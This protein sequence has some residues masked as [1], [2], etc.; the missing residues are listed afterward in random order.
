[1]ADVGIKLS[2]TETA[3]SVAPK[4]CESLRN[5][6]QAGQDMND[7]LQLGDLEEKYK[8]FADRVDKIHDMQKTGQREI[9]KDLQ[10]TRA[11]ETRLKQV[12]QVVRGAGAAVQQAGVTG[13]PGIGSLLGGITSA[14]GPWGMI[15]A[16]LT[17]A[18]VAANALSRQYEKVLPTIMDVTAAFSELRSTTIGTSDSFEKTMKGAMK[19]TQEFG[20]S[21]EQGLTTMRT[22]AAAGVTRAGALEQMGGREGIF[23]WARG[24]GATAEML[25]RYQAMGMRFGVEPSLGFAAG[26]LRQAGMGLGQFQEYLNATLSIFEEGLSRGVVQGFEDI[27]LAQ[28]WISQLGDAFK[29]QYGLNL[30]K[31]MDQAAVKATELQSES[32]VIMF[33]AARR[34][35]K[36]QG[37]D[38]S[39]YIDVMKT[40]E[41]GAQY[42]PA[43]FGQ[44]R[45]IL[46]D[47][48]GGNVNDMAELFREIYG[49]NY[50]VAEQLVGM[51]DVS[52]E[53]LDTLL[54]PRADSPQLQLLKVQ[55]TLKN[56][57]IGIGEDL[58][59]WKGQAFGHAESMIGYLERIA[60]GEGMVEPGTI[61]GQLGGKAVPAFQETWEIVRPFTWRGSKEEREGAKLGRQ[62]IR[63]YAPELQEAGFFE[64][65][66]ARAMAYS[67]MGE[68]EEYGRE[69]RV[70]EHDL[71]V[72]LGLLRE[73]LNDLKISLDRE[74]L[75]I[76]IEALIPTSE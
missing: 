18:G 17:A 22:F 29:G 38:T 10:S 56:K 51:K 14:L 33:R 45:R 16:G 52:K 70:S 68:R 73:T 30:F 7:A 9:V 44:L 8:A 12:P 40:L 74:E 20:Y 72:V 4:V 47:M 2:M 55:Q 54:A 46:E 36:E 19:A 24:T 3:S 28:A 15:L 63:K 75:Q 39:N 49:V 59:R 41:S 42:T 64:K 62:L 58:A 13:E 61:P 69:K 71:P 57:I 48:T 25:S 43:L 50:I 76:I 37:L 6:S 65:V 60:K 66:V 67:P 32:D 35:M 26:G 23:A 1:V 5:I 34:M 53:Q 31:N 27:N 11:L 21:L